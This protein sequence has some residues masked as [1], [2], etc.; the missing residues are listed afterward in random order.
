MT[1]LLHFCFCSPAAYAFRFRFLPWLC[2]QP[3]SWL[4]PRSRPRPCPSCASQSRVVLW[5]LLETVLPEQFLQEPHAHA[6]RRQALR[7]WGELEPEFCTKFELMSFK[8]VFIQNI[9]ASTAYISQ[10]YDYESIVC[11]HSYVNRVMNIR[12]IH[13]APDCVFKSYVIPNNE[14]D[15]LHW[16][17]P[18]YTAFLNFPDVWFR[19]I[20]IWSNL[21]PNTVCRQEWQK[22]EALDLN[23]LAIIIIIY[24]Y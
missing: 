11:R 3:I 15:V 24:I 10:C 19:N 23:T 2:V 4:R 22:D 13:F 6:L 9:D 20:L 16:C 1:K 7:L 18:M 8:T 17:T 5:R 14:T 12:A 21:T